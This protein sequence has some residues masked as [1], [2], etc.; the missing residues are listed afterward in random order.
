MNI[1]IV[2]RGRV[3]SALRRGLEADGDHRIAVRGRGVS[4]SAVGSAD[5]I[6]LA[7]PDDAIRDVAAAISPSLEA[8]ACVL[9]CAGARDV[10]ELST[11]RAR[12]A[13]TGVMHPLVSFP[14]RRSSP[15][16][17]GA[18]FTI[19]G[20]RRAL[21][22]SRKIAAACG[23]RAVVAGTGNPAYHA[24]A[25]LTANGAAALAFASVG[26]LRYLGFE[27]RAAERAIGGLLQS[28]GDNV[29]RLGVPEALTGPIARGEA[30]TVAAHRNALRHVG[31]DAL[32][33]Y[34][35]VL[36]VIVRCARAAGLA[37]VEADRILGLAKR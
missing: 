22:A 27:R 21:A 12:G 2:G 31:G 29:Q 17:Q 10:E 6:V 34:D 4:P 37:K 32:R 36:P 14:S 26:V 24:A 20:S 3:G 11:C 23:A 13:A 18:T 19:R 30:T 15:S 1:L 7:V 35:S 9:H 28:V 25:A 8:K 33:A 5:V 16:L